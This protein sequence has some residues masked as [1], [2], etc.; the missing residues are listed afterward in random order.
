VNSPA[1]PL[2]LEYGDGPGD[3]RV[4]RQRPPAGAATFSATYLAPAGWA[5]DPVGAAGTARLVNQ[6]VT[7]GAGPWGRV[8]LARRLDRAGA[9]LAADTS[10]ESA[11]VTVWGPAD[12]WE[13]LMRILAEVV[14]RPRFDATDIA[15]ARRQMQE[16]QMRQ[17]THPAAR[18]HFELLHAIFPARHPYR[19]TGL[20][21]AR[22]LARIDR[23]GLRR[24]HAA[25]Y[26]ST[27]ALLVVTASAGV[28]V[29][30]RVARRWF[31]DLPKGETG[32]LVLPRLGP[33]RPRRVEVDLSGQ[34][35]VEVRVGGVSIPRSAL[36]YP[37]GFLANQLLGA[38]PLIARLFQT[39]REKSGLAYGASS[40]LETM[41]YGGWWVAG[42]GTGAER[43][44][45]VVPLV[46]QEVA[47][48]RTSL[49]GA[50]EL[51]RTR[52][53]AIGEIPLG[54]ETTAE[55]HE[56]A[57]HAAYHQ[58][59]S[60]FWRTWPGRLRAVSRRDV[61]EGAAAAFDG[62]RSV[63]VVVGPLHGR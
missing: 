62:R 3:L 55:A 36:E 37:G 45:R 60:D 34:S 48:M 12:G 17:R 61:R 38:R 57:V 47:R 22:A 33:A 56:L 32:R 53:S 23:A 5:F 63:T 49:V 13:P 50:S 41:R 2:Q 15:R 21:D 58:L 42:A 30:Q 54:F 59:P 39:V 28:P 29:L 8:A 40:R 6:L 11:E 4:V 1:G 7:S 25:R 43:W 26:G 9:T 44:K 16:R 35:Q 24:F 52:E 51:E 14:R 31:G 20:G 46:E 27:D 19:E 18:A 10:P